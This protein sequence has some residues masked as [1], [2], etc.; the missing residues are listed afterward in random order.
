MV[1]V[2]GME[3]LI[4]ARTG[5]NQV[6]RI[7]SELSKPAR[8]PTQSITDLG[9]LLRAAGQSIRR[10]SLMFVASDF[11]SAPGWESHLGVLSR[12]HEVIAVR[13]V[14]PLE[15]RLPDVGSLTL[16]DSETGEQL[17]VDTHDPVFR[18]RYEAAASAREAGLQVAF[19]HAGVDCLWLSTEDDLVRSLVRF[20]ALRGRKRRIH[21]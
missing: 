13:V 2:S 15:R 4:A 3:K 19:K 10:R 18:R 17:Y 14:H 21:R 6:L 8:R 1:L 11:V 7:I 16:Q 20:A 12:R 5:R 9:I